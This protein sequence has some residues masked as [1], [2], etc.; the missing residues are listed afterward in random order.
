MKKLIAGVVAATVVAVSLPVAAQQKA[1]PA[2]VAIPS[3]VF[4]KGQQPNQILARDTV[5]FAK[6]RGPD[7]KIIG[8]V[9]DLIMTENNEL[10]GVIIGVGGIA[11]LGEKRIGVRYTALQIKTEG[12]KTVVTL[13]GATK[14]VL[15]ALAPYQRT[16]PA[17][18]LLDRAFD[19]AKELSDKTVSTSSDLYQQAK[20]ATAPAL[21]KAK[22]ATKDAIEKAKGAA[23]PATPAE[24]KKQ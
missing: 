5:L 3:N 7:G 6:V 19:K 23:Q 1:A 2:P 10:I 16:K 18:S 15:K 21:E 14:E 17:Q 20:E 8:D 13:P 9:E 4:F 11:G 24:P 12:G 22:E